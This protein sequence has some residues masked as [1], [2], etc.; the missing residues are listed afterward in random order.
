MQ[1]I[2]WHYVTKSLEGV[3]IKRKRHHS[4]NTMSLGVTSIIYLQ[5]TFRNMGD[6][7]PIRSF[8]SKQFW[9]DWYEQ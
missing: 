8:G 5:A 9:N 4:C 1:S 7:R 3:S 2:K 6:H